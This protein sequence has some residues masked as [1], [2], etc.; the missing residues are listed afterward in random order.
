[1]Y[2]KVLMNTAM[3]KFKVFLESNPEP[4]L[5]ITELVG[6]IPSH[7]FEDRESGMV[8]IGGGFGNSEAGTVQQYS[9]LSSFAS[10]RS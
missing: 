10:L 2:S 5:N 6:G 4:N 9:C 3:D 8:D 7:D 1:M